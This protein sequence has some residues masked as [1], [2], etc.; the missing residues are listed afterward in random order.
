[1]DDEFC[2]PTQPI[3]PALEHNFVFDEEE[4]E[5]KDDESPISTNISKQARVSESQSSIRDSTY[6]SV[7][8]NEDTP[9]I[10]HK[11][12][13]VIRQT[14]RDRVQNYKVKLSP[15]I[16]DPDDHTR[17]PSS[18]KSGMKSEVS[19][20]S[21]ASPSLDESVARSRVLGTEVLPIDIVRY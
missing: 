16:R 18:R 14:L 12:V 13:P 11:K 17:A 21:T 1:M 3:C 8:Q 10:V 9:Y 20:V 4:N 15:H 2:E 5:E 6:S 7:T 19:F